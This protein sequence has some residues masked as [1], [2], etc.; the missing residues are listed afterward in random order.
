MS[1]AGAVSLVAALFAAVILVRFVMLRGAARPPS[2]WWLALGLVLLPLLS[3]G[4]A[5]VHTLQK[6]TRREFCGSC[7]V[8]GRHLADL[9]DPESQGLAA[10]H[11]KN[12]FFGQKACYTCHANY[13]LLG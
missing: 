8:M 6:S 5:T 2:R 1:L 10:R 4:A 11:A 7:H 9:D 13:G 3:N 12:A